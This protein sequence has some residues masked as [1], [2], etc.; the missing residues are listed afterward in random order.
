MHKEGVQVRTGARTVG[1]SHSHKDC[2]GPQEVRK[3]PLW[4]PQREW[5][6]ATP[7]VWPSG[8]ENW[9][10]MNFCCGERVTKQT[11]RE[12]PGDLPHL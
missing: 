9:E 6:L 8:L 7:G 3:R 12:R 5:V 11:G 10:R 1:R 4:G 2:Q